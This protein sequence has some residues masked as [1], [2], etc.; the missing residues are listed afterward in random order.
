MEWTKHGEKYVLLLTEEEAGHIR[1]ALGKLPWVNERTMKFFRRFSD[2]M[3]VPS[4]SKLEE[5]EE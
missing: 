2:E 1:Y 5:I 3:N 4:Y